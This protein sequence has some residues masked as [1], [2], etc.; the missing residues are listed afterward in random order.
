MLKYDLNANGEY[1]TFPLQYGSTK[2][3]VTLYQNVEGSKYKAKGKVA[4]SPK[5]QDELRCYLYPN[6]YVNYTE[7][8][9]CVKV[10]A[11]LCRDMTDQGQIFKAVH[12]YIVS[13][14]QYDYIKSMTVKPGTLPDIDECWKGKKGICQDLSATTCAMLRSQGVPA[15]LV[16]GTLDASTP[17]AWVVAMVDGKEVFFD[18]TAELESVS[19]KH[20][21]TT[22]RWY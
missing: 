2:Y 8:T 4:V 10:A 9:E 13:N 11:D 1:E 19:R 5:M 7:K 18:P 12:K 6:Q 17:H 15:R 3:T 14:F 16:I 22:E 20:T 21:Y